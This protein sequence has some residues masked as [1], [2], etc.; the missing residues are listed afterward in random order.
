MNAD[1]ILVMDQGKVVEMGV[2][3]ELLAAGGTYARL[4]QHQLM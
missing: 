2:H 4:I 1:R 3:D